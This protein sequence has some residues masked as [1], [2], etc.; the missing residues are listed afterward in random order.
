MSLVKVKDKYQVTI[1]ENIRNK[2]HCEIGELLDVSVKGSAIVL[3]PMVVEERYSDDELEALEKAFK[4]PRNR[5]KIM[6]ADEFK[7]YQESL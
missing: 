4:S 7:K 3:K 5:G 2:I 1:P 6:T